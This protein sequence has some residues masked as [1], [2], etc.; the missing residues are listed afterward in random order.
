MKTLFT[1]RFQHKG[2]IT[3]MNGMK[4]RFII[5]KPL[6]ELGMLGPNGVLLQ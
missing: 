6:G 3:T 1:G 5:A 4:E 2:T